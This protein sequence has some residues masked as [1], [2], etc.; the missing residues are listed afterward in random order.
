MGIHLYRRLFIFPLIRVISSLSTF[1]L[2]N[3]KGDCLV[4]GKIKQNEYLISALK[5]FKP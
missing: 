5:F 4:K 2:R 1:I 3:P